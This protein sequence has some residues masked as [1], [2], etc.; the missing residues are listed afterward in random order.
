MSPSLH[1][2]FRVVPGEGAK[3]ATFALFAALLQSGVA[4]G[5]AAADSLFLAQLGVEWLPVFYLCIPV[6]MALYAPVSAVLQARFGV[7]RLVYATLGLLV[8]G[9]LCFGL[10][11]EVAGDSGWFPFVMKLYVGVLYIALYT[12]FWNFADDYFSILDSKRLYGLIA[13]GGAGGA[14]CGAALVGWFI[15]FLPP[16]RM[17][18]VWA[19]LAA[20]AVPVFV[21]LARRFPRIEVDAADT[22]DDAIHPGRLLR[23]I[24]GTFRSSR[25]ALAIT[26]ICFCAAT[27]TGVMEYL[28]LG[29]LAEGKSAAELAGLLGRL[30]AVANA[31]TLVVNLVLFNRIVGRLGVNNTALILPLAYLAVFVVLYLKSGVAAALVAFFV[32]QSL[33]LSVEYNNINLL[34]NALPALVKRQ[35]R[36]FIEA[37]GE[38]LATALAGVFLLTWASS[39]GHGNLALCGLL[40][41]IVAVAL[42]LLVRHDY[43]KALSVNLRR[44][45]LDF[46]LPGRRWRE[47]VTD[48]DRQLFR[49]KALTSA[50]RPERALAVD[51]LGY[52]DDP[53]ACSALLQIVSTARPAEAERLRPAIRR[54]IQGGDTATIAQTL[55]WLESD[56]G[57]EEPELLDE[58]TAAGVMPLRHLHHWRTS[59]HPSRIAMSAVARWYSSRIEDTRSALTDVANLLQGDPTT[60]RWGVRALGT[61]RHSHHARELLRFLDDPDRELRIETLRALHRMAG[62]DSG[63]VLERLLAYVAEATADERS[64]VLGIAARIGDEGAV[65][66]LLR[67]AEYFSSA[68]SHQLEEFI[69]G[70][71]LKTVPGLIHLLRDPSATCRSRALAARALARLALPELEL[72]VDELIDRSLEH[73][74]TV[75]AAGRTFAHQPATSG[76]GLM[77]L[78]RFYHDSAADLLDFVL[79]LL[80]LTGRLPD[81]DLIRASLSFANPKDRAN[82]IETIAQSSPRALFERLRPLIE[83]RGLRHVHETGPCEPLPAAL[84]RAS[85]SDHPV[86]C[87]AALLAAHEL[88]LPQSRDW[89]H[90]SMARSSSARTTAWLQDLW[91]RFHSATTGALHPVERIAA[92]AR[93]SVFDGAR[94]DAL[95]FLAS[96]ASE[97]ALPDQTLLFSAERPAD[98]LFVLATGTIELSQRGRSRLLTTGDYLNERVLMGSIQRAESAHSRGCVVLGLTGATV[99]GAIEIFPSLGISLFRVKTA[100]ALP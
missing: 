8:A 80:S 66:P 97:R 47:Q 63:A 85:S 57:P 12:L 58:F 4:V 87:A 33:L 88:Q 26:A 36:T 52:V 54:M 17:F 96:R 27:L 75:T 71:G 13:A 11:A 79:Q 42:A 19:A 48:A 41:S 70:L 55:L 24:L 69:L 6:L 22:D 53:Q 31:V 98:E 100:R 49:Q 35:L 28:S 93:S 92:L 90:Q 82:A 68:E 62:P 29:I 74:Q 10:G 64:L 45:W 56:D 44:D 43:V 65:A 73:A 7:H 16:A 94:I 38:P 32:Y 34:F 76:N 20:A 9:G 91:P 67:A 25:F 30:H 3:V 83:G 72:I 46:A 51:L 15:A 37:M 40:A 89:L 99:A 78:V 95:D 14:M 23:V 61:F 86:E 5:M 81:F 84:Q 1:R 77:V 50:S 18:L 59:Q 39:L 21:M 60:R 2:L